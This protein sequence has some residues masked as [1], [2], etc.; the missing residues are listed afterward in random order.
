MESF[1]T[2]LHGI[3]MC[4]WGLHI[5]GF[6]DYSLCLVILFIQWTLAQSTGV[7]VKQAHAVLF[8]WCRERKKSHTL[9][10][11]YWLF[12]PRKMHDGLYEQH[13]TGKV[14]ALAAAV[15]VTIP[16]KELWMHIEGGVSVGQGCLFSLFLHLRCLNPVPHSVILVLSSTPESSQAAFPAVSF[17]VLMVRQPKWRK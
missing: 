9:F 5:K 14:L 2:L 3:Y 1:K 16:L 8:I 17:L 10:V 4:S 13:I 15:H 7:F 12:T 6:P 11:I